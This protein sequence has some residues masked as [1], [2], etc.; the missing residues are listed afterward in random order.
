MSN[1]SLPINRRVLTVDDNTSIHED[2]RRALCQSQPDPGIGALEASIFG[3]PAKA[4]PR[5]MESFEVDQALQGKEA[6]EKLRSALDS[7]K[8][9]AVVFVDMRMPPGWDG[10][11]TIEHLWQAD[12]SVL[13]VI[14][15]A[16]SDY[17]WSDVLSRL[18]RRDQLLLLRKPFDATEVWQMAESLCHRW[19]I[20]QLQVKA[21]EGANE[22][23]SLELH[24]R[25]RAEERLRHVA[26]HDQLTSLPNR[27][28]LLDRLG[29][30]IERQQRHPAEVSAVMYLDLDNFKIVNDSLG[31]RAGDAVLIEA[32]RRLAEVVRTTDTVGRPMDS[33]AARLGGD[34]FVVLLQDVSNASEALRTADRV[35]Q[36][37]SA[38]YV[39]EGRELSLSAS[40]GI[41]IAGGNGQTPEELLRDADTAMY[42]AKYSG[43]GRCALFDAPMH[44][45]VLNRMNLEA[46]LRGAAARGELAVVYQP[47]VN[48]ESGAIEGFEALL[49]WNHP[50]LGSV[51]P[52]AFIPIAEESGIINA[53][54]G[55]TLNIVSQTL[56]GWRRDFP[57][58]AGI[59]VS[60]NVSRRQLADPGLPGSIASV[61]ERWGLLPKDVA[62]EITE[63]AVMQ[64]QEAAM[65]I[66]T[67][68]RARGF[69]IMMDDFGTGYSSLSCL[70]RFPI[71]VLKIDRAFVQ[72]HQSNRDYAAVVHSIITLAHNLGSVVI[73]EG[74]ET[75][76]HLAQL[77]ALECDLAQ[78]YLFSRPV[79]ASEIEAMLRAKPEFRAVAA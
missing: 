39:H 44:T 17:E 4:G 26:L 79:P 5:A 33:L 10:V 38:P 21:L 56:Q 20:A 68:L 7:G 63:S 1:T 65:G 36:A 58:A 59:Y 35:L 30:C 60:V 23:L 70:H 32:A 37:L 76:E 12:P 14:C 72:T 29:Q 74:V 6:L 53:I 64:H 77:Q 15:S 62:F 31:H 50:T 46:D 78:G 41:A 25:E 9:Y 66:L 73:A 55:W 11:E 57:I 52:D 18:P 69:K 22:Q 19:A 40:I 45:A 49:R 67:D 47:I 2:Y 28:L 43:K 75:P 27:A 42:Q 54:S 8:P 48:I 71:D 51:P 13:V 34:E 3:A 24:E 16:Y 61:V